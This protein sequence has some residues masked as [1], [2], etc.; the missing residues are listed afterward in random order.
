[1]TQSVI[2]HLESVSK[3]FSRTT[4]PAVQNVNLKLYQ[5]DILGLLGPSGCG[6]TTLLRII[7]GFEQPQLGIVTI[8]GRVVAGRHDWVVPEKRNVGMVFQDYALFPHL[9]VAKN[10]AFGL[11][12]SGKKSRTEINHQVKDVLELVGLSGL[13]NRYPHELSGGQQQRVALARALAPS[14]ALV[15]LDEPLS[16]LDVQVRMRLR[17]ELRDILKNAGASGI[18][19]T[20]DQEE[21]MAISD[22]VAVMR[23]GC[24]EQFGT[25]EEIYNEPASKFVAEFVTQAN[26]LPAHRRD[27][28]WETEVGAFELT[29][30]HVFRGEIG[31]LDEFDHLELMIRQEDLMLKVDDEGSMVI[32]DRQFLGR[33]FRYCLQTESG[34]E[35]IARTT[36][37]VALPIGIQVKVSVAEDN[38]RVFPVIPE[39]KYG[40]NSKLVG[41]KHF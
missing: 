16:N 29:N 6:K 31:S 41:S 20:H 38:L 15:L 9:T 10:I 13:E 7:A 21:A 27:E 28:L 8:N 39:E 25:P 17:Q 4:T 26:F 30:N 36:P 5:G 22:R 35:L 12:N 33:E 40:T 14:P 19:V 32:R 23:A 3:Q 24:V 37:Q 1:M 34:K 18:I 2:L 11:H